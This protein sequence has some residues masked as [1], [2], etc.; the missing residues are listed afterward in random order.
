MNMVQDVKESHVDSAKTTQN[1]PGM[2]NALNRHQGSISQKTR[3]SLDI[4]MTGILN[5]K[6]LLANYDCINF[7]MITLLTCTWGTRDSAT[8]S[9]QKIL[10]Q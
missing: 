8:L 6:A 7:G 2:V 4:F 3:Q 9:M 1:L 5:I 10:L